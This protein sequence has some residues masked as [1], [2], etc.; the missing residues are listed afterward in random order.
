LVE[1][2]A[3]QSGDRGL[4][5]AAAAIRLEVGPVHEAL[6]F[7]E[8]AI[9]PALFGGAPADRELWMLAYPRAFWN[10]VEST[11]EAAGVDPY[12]VLAVMREESRFDPQV[13]SIAGAIGLLQLLPGTASGIAGTTMSATQLTQPEVNIR[14]GTAYLAGLLRRFRGDIPLALAG[15]NAGPGAAQR[16]SRISRAD[17]DLFFERIPYA[18]TRAYVQRVLQTYGIYRWLY[19]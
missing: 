5:R 13:A 17:M 2:E 1:E 11:A 3:A 4:L 12:L 19:R 7:S 6:R 8:P 9:A 15:Y 14:L 18:E 16:F 10:T